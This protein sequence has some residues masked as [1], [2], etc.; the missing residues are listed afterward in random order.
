MTDDETRMRALDDVAQMVSVQP[1]AT[2]S[3]TVMRTEGGN[4]VLFSFD[5]GQEL[6]EHTAAM[7]VFVQTLSGRLLVRG[8]DEER[9]AVPGDL[10]YFPTRLPH[11]IRALEPSVMMLTMIT[12]AR[13][14]D[15]ID[16]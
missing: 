8:G 6:S 4:V 1:E 7:P 16:G 5:A 14:H 13:A 3:R 10:I 12:A 9:E 11:A 15:A 2:V